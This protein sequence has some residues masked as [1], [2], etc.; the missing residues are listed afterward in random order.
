MPIVNHLQQ[1]QQ[2]IYDTA[3]TYHRNPHDIKLIGVT[4]GQTI[5]AIQAAFANGLMDF[6][7]N[8]CQEAQEKMAQLS[9]LAIHWHFI[10]PIQSNKT[11]FIANHFEWV[12]SVSR[13]KIATLLSTHRASHLPPLQICLQVNLDQEASKSGILPAELPLLIEQISN[14]PHLKLRGLMSIPKPYDDE[15]EQYQSFDRLTTLMAHLN[16]SM[17]LKLD[18]LSMG[19]SHDFVAAIRAGSTMVRIGEAIFGKRVPK[20]IEDSL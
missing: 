10:G 6:A 11:K 12:H 14:L 20:N 1:I 17:H 18:T 13:I 2:I 4:K 15:T 5:D 19:M 3:L 8:Y 9:D 16:D 7:E